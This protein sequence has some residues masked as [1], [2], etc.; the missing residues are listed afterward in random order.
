MH[1]GE[2]ACF[3]LCFRFSWTYAREWNHTAS[4]CLA[5]RGPPDCFP[6]QLR[7]SPFP[8]A[9]HEGSKSSADVWHF[10]PFVRF[11]FLMT[12]TLIGVR[13]CLV[14]AVICIPPAISDALIF[15][16]LLAIRIS[17]FARRLFGSLAHFKAGRSVFLPLSCRSPLRSLG[18]TP[19]SGPGRVAFSHPVGC[20]LTLLTAPFDAQSFSFR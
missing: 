10:C 9:T 2:H 16:C 7:R 15:M 19:P 18:V 1:T 6:R 17:P 4:L 12:A 8:P 14:V 3:G 11:C 5:F 13:Q 20:L